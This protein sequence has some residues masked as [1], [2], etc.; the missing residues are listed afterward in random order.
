MTEENLK[1][2]I[3]ELEYQVEE[4]SDLLYQKEILLKNIYSSKTWRLGQL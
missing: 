2:R 3:K 1:K 4:L